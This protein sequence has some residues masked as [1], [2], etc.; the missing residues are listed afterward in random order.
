MSHLVMVHT[1][2]YFSYFMNDDT[3]RL[4][5]KWAIR[6]K[7]DPF[8]QKN[9]KQY[10]LKWYIHMYL[11]SIILTK[12]VSFSSGHVD[13]TYQE[14]D[15]KED[16]AKTD[17]WRTTYFL[18]RECKRNGCHS[19]HIHR[20]LFCHPQDVLDLT[21]HIYDDD[22]SRNP[23]ELDD[24]DDVGMLCVSKRIRRRGYVTCQIPLHHVGITYDKYYQTPESSFDTTKNVNQASYGTSFLK[25]LRRIYAKQ[26]VSRWKT[27]SRKDGLYASIHP[28]Q[29]A[30]VM[31]RILDASSR[32][33]SETTV[34]RVDQYCLFFR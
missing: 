33:D 31:K 1:H 3:C 19:R 13:A 18:I 22:A 7:H 9:V 2:E 32:E 17:G 11:L 5:G 14:E 10:L 27:S 23:N 28:C 25:T 30:A 12:A 20:R 24:D 4:K 34:L 21:R 26:T 6:S 16:V 15:M 8:F 29:H